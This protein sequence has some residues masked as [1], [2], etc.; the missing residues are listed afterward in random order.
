MSE[1]L[2]QRT[3]RF[4]ISIINLSEELG[5]S[6]AKKVVI[7]QL[8]RSASSVGANYRAATRARSDREFIAKLRIVLEEVDESCFWLEI[9]DEKKW[10]DVQQLLLE[11]NQ[12]TAIIVK[13]IKKNERKNR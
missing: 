11:A 12:L 4:T 2:K 3:K 9:I 7:N 10:I 5:Y 8:L 1:E 13:S 6:A